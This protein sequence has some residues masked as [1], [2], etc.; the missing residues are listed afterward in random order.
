MLTIDQTH[1]GFIVKYK[2]K[3]ILKHSK[4]SPCCNFGTGNASYS[5]H[6]GSYKIKENL[7]YKTSL[8]KFK[9]IETNASHLRIHFSDS[10]NPSEVLE[11]IIRNENR[12]IVIIPKIGTL[13]PEN[14][15]IIDEGKKYNRFWIKLAANPDEAIYGCGE[16]YSELNLRGKKLPLWVEEQ[17]IGRGDPKWITWLA[18]IKAGAG[19]KW[20]TTYYPQPTFISTDHYFCHVDMTSYSVFDFICSDFHLLHSWEIPKQII[21]EYHN[22]LLDTVS[23]LS[24][25]LGRQPKLAD[26]VYDGMWLAIQGKGGNQAVRNRLQKAL[27][28]KVLVSGIW[29]QDWQGIVTTPFGTQLF[30][31]WKW[32]GKGRPVRFDNFPEFVKEMREKGIRY[33]GYINSF[34]NIEGEQFKE[35]SKKGL[36]IKNRDGTD[37]ITKTTTFPVALLDL[38]N[39]A[40][41][42]WIKD[43]IKQNLINEAGLS[44][45]MSDFGEYLPPDAALHSGESGESYH[46]HFPVVWQRL[47]LEAVQEAGKSEEIVFFTR[48]GYSH[49][50]KY[51]TMVWAGDQMPNWSMGDG[52]ASVIPAGL[53]LGLCGIG[54]YHSD[55]GGFTSIKPVVRKKENFMRWVEHSTFTMLMRTHEGIKPEINWQFDSDQETLDHLARMTHIHA[56]MKPYLQ[57]ISEEYQTTGIPPMRA[58]VLHYESDP[59]VR[60]LKYQY[61]FGKDLLV[62]PV[63]KKKRKSWK[64]YIPD[65]QWINIW[66]GKDCMKGWQKYAAPLGKPPVFYRKGTRFTNIFESIQKL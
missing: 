60:D 4:D 10:T 26:W 18:D 27:D 23:G 17:G 52:L 22:T 64:V 47:N 66:T 38:S 51:T 28:A 41:Q 40:T 58:M 32:D 8:T 2:N 63:I 3:I 16:Q 46:N 29:S 19:G 30:W 42:I 54:Y 15:L 21:L 31:D 5:E 48:S 34:L 45:W 37:F 14:T 35:A 24:T 33:L 43:I 1:K 57:H 61:L 50:S 11:I 7:F 12:R 55:I 59:E 62:A 44:G 25:F 65:D 53:S 56:I 20:Y 49:T 39:P 36:V 6:L 13:S 9:I